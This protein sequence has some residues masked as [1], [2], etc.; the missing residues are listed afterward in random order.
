M[1]RKFPLIL[2]NVKFMVNPTMLK[3][4]KTVAISSL[5]TQS[6]VKF[7]VWYDNPEMLTISGLSAGSSA[8]QELQFLK[9]NFER[10]D[11]ESSL[12]YKT[13]IY[14]GIITK[15]DTTFT[16]DSPNKFNYDIS[17][18]LKFG[19]KFKIEDFSLQP[20]SGAISDVLGRVE[21]TMNLYLDKASQI[22]SAIKL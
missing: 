14:T 4:N 2:N 9:T 21:D 15:L 12:Y 5:N 10:A 17:F 22:V 3:L 18:Q 8:Y 6:G 13:T 20:A 11:K 19:Q 16:S 1:A 7:Y